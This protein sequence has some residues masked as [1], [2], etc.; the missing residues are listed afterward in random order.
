MDHLHLGISPALSSLYARN[1]VASLQVTRVLIGTWCLL[2]TLEW[3]SNF[4]LFKSDGLLSWRILALRPGLMF[5][6]SW[7]QSLFW[8]RS[9]AWVLSVR[10][11]AAIG[12]MLTANAAL[13]C[14]LL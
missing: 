4:R 5:R 2:S 1:V 13:E 3:V 12:L 11:A 10:I 8:E 6:S 9:P 7:A 14:V